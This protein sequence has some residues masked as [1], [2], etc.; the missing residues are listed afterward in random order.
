LPISALQEK[1]KL[2]ERCPLCF[3]SV[4][5]SSKNNKKVNSLKDNLKRHSAVVVH[6]LSVIANSR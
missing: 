4:A 2:T 5:T 6:V 1:K 3:P